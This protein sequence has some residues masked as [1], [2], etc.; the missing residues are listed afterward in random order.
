M[1]SH[2]SVASEPALGECQHHCEVRAGPKVPGQ[3]SIVRVETGNNPGIWLLVTA[4]HM[5]D[6]SRKMI[7]CRRQN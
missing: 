1:V 3:W 2:S 6:S 5:Q 4:R 7:V